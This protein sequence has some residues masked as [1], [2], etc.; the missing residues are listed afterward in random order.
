MSDTR[1]VCP[2]C[3]TALKVPEGCQGR[4]VR[5]SKCS[6]RFQVP[7]EGTVAD[8]LVASWLSE[9]EVQ[10]R[11]SSAGAGRAAGSAAAPASGSAATPAA[12]PAAAPAVREAPG[13]APPSLRAVGEAPQAAGAH[14][15]PADHAA[16]LRV[17]TIEPNGVLLEFP[18]ARLLDASFRA[19]FPRRC[20]SC[21]AQVH[22]RAHMIIFAARL[23]D[24]FSLEAEHSAGALALSNDE[25]RGLSNEEVLSRLPRI[26]NVPP[27]ADLPMP[28]WVCDMCSC[29]GAGLLSGQFQPGGADEKGLCRLWVGS[30]H[31]ALEVMGAAGAEGTPDYAR[32]KER[33]ESTAEN[34][35]DLLPSVIRHRLEQWFHPESHERFLAYVPD[36]DHARTEDGMAGV[37]ITDRR[38][39]YHTHARHRETGIQDSVDLEPSMSGSK[40][41]VRIRTSGWEVHHFTVDRDGLAHM[42]R[43]LTVGRFKAHWR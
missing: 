15:Q 5:C 23:T 31:R 41:N 6:H 24:S 11:D 43:A 22:L 33:V 40:H 8:D 3:G 25:V 30:M 4:F 9:E 34:P 14:A 28:Y 19:A 16:V 39:I 32:L 27:P 21:G 12:G 38:L 20:L 17:V 2:S 42:R 7:E 1:V 26:P 18:A 13:G 10:E 36:R 35:W 37:V 29:S